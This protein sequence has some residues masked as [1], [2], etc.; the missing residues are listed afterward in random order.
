[1]ISQLFSPLP[2]KKEREKPDFSR[3]L[4]LEKSDFFKK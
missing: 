4:P 2:E 3:N 1:M